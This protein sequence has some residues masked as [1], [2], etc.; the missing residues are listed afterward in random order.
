ME[1]DR[2]MQQTESAQTTEISTTVAAVESDRDMQQTESAQMTEAPTTVAAVESDRDMD[3]DFV[4]NSDTNDSLEI[5]LIPVSFIFSHIWLHFYRAML[6]I[7]WYSY[8]HSVT[9]S[10]H[11]SHSWTVP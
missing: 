6:C 3:V 4:A 10:V 9:R 2:E 5:E 1:S 8:C 11:L 7:A